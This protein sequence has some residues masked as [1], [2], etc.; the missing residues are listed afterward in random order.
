M[1]ALFLFK[2]FA[3][4]AA[5]IVSFGMLVWPGSD[6]MTPPAIYASLLI[7]VIGAG[8]AITLLLGR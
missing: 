2:I 8:A 6:R 7:A 1:E 3:I 4:V 5:L